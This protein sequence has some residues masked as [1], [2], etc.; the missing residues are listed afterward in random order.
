[1]ATHDHYRQWYGAFGGLRCSGKRL[2]AM[3]DLAIPSELR[4]CFVMSAMQTV[5]ITIFA[6]AGLAGRSTSDGNNGS[7][8]SPGCAASSRLIAGRWFVA[9]S[10]NKNGPGASAKAVNLEGAQHS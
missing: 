5:D 1:M 10:T 8:I 3:I 7:T 6:V 4:A 9:G 2:L